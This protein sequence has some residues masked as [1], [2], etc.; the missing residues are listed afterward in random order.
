MA[1]GEISLGSAVLR[2]Y[3]DRSA[4]DKEIAAAMRDAQRFAQEAVNVKLGADTS[5]ANSQI[6]GLRRQVGSLRADVD[7]LNAAMGSMPRG[8]AG[9]GAGWQQ[10]GNTM[11]IVAA[12]ASTA[13][14]AVMALAAAK[15]SLLAGEV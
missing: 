11:A 9:G 4:L 12:N 6:D 7:R 14:N 1:E 13:A 15:K 5:Q 10:F 2:L 8:P 3:G